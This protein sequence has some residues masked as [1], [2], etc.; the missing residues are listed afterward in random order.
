M[1]VAIIGTRGIP[2]HYGGFEQFAQYLSDGLTQMGHQVFVYNSHNHPFQEN[3]WKNVNLIHCFDPEYKLGTFGQFFYDLNCIL[4]SR[5]RDYDVILQLGYTS[6]SIWNVLF[7]TGVKIVTNMDGLEW[8]RSKFSRPTKWFLKIAEWLAVKFSDELISDSVGIQDY[9]YKTHK[10]SS[11]YIPYGAEVC[12]RPKQSQLEIYDLV[13]YEYDILV[14][15][16]EPENN[17]ETII[18]GFIS[19]NVKRKL[20]V[21]GSLNTV[22]AKRLV[23][24]ISDE[25]IVFFDFITSI[26]I[27]NALRYY[28][29][30]YFHGHTVGG[31]NPSLLEAMSSNALVCAHNN[32]FNKSILGND[33]FYFENSKDVSSLLEKCQKQNY[34]HLCQ[35]NIR[36]IVKTYNYLDIIFKYEQVLRKF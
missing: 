34:Q 5:K 6:S 20:V 26:D 28:S 3:K 31:T 19:S 35:A 12:E 22:L 14:A 21:V 33:A 13:P 15:R 10:V 32:I 9:L 36:K 23:N 24:I 29:N 2:N 7:K 27:L 16:I 8:K 18:E 30:I 4:D 25:R 11:T 1:K 17:I